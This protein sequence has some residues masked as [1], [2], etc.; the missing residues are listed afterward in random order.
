MKK[1]MWAALDEEGNIIKVYKRKVCDSFIKVWVTDKDP[2]KDPFENVREVLKRRI[3][4][5]SEIQNAAI[6][7]LKNFDEG[8]K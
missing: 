3:I 8:V 4:K 5:F 6:L 2:V 7:D 1:K